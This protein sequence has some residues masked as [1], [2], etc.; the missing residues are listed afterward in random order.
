MLQ[1]TGIDEGDAGSQ[2][3]GMDAGQ[4]RCLLR[5]A[6]NVS[7]DPAIVLRAGMDL[8]I[9]THGDLGIV[10]ATAPTL[11]ALLEVFS[12]FTRVRNPYGGTTL[13]DRGNYI[14][15]VAEM[16]DE[17]G[18][19][20]DLALDLLCA[21]FASG[22]LRQAG[23]VVSS[24]TLK[25]GR[26]RPENADTYSR[27]LDLPIAWEQAVT[28]FVFPRRD[29]DRPLPGDNPEEF[30]RAVTRLKSLYSLMLRPSSYREAVVSV[31]T[32]QA[33]RICTIATVAD[34]LHTSPRTRNRKLKAE[35]TGFQRML[36][37][38]LSQQAINYL[39]DGGLTVEATAALM[40]YGDEANFRRAFRRWHGC[41]PRA[42]RETRHANRAER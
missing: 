31:F 17:L 24:S 42:Y 3:R 25:M 36:D 28:A 11:R 10:T 18:E 19:E 30:A 39:V 13:V 14:E 2:S 15:L 9:T 27:L 7:G 12:N 5:N 26:A 40:G 32:Q 16:S 38:W 41:S 22:P 8:P 23:P 4:Y 1:G 34:A 35:G 21:A 20:R 33:G 29:L 37:S 6:V